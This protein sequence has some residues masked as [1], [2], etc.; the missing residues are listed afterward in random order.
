M[1]VSC[2]YYSQTIVSEDFE[3]SITLFTNSGGVFYTG[4]SATGDRPASSPFAQL[5]SYGIGVTNGT[6]ILT[7]GDINTSTCSGVQLSFKLAAFSIASTG[8]GMDAGDYVSIE[9]SPDG[10]TTY[11]NTLQV[12]GN[13][14]AYWAYATGTGTANTAYDGNVTPVTIAPAGGAA[15]TTDGYSSLIV[16]GLPIVTNLR[17]RITL[18]NNAASERWVMDN[19]ILSGSC[20]SCTAPTTTISPTTQTVCA[21]T[22]TSFTVGSDATSPT[23]TWQASAN[24]TT[25]WANAVNATPTGVTYTGVNTFSLGITGTSAVT[26]YYRVLVAEGGT[27]TATSATST[28]VISSPPSINTHPNSATISTSSSG[29]FTVVAIGGGLSYQWQQNSGGGF[30]NITNGGSNPTYAGATTSVLTISNPPLSMSG[31]S[32]QCVVANNC[33]TVTTNG[34]ATLN[35]ISTPDC[36]YITSVII[37]SCPGT[38]TV[39]AEGNSEAVFITNGASVLNTTTSA[40]IAA[41]IKLSYGTTAAG[42][43]LTSSSV[44]NAATASALACLNSKPGCSGVFVDALGANIPAGAQ[45]MVVRSTF[46]CPTNSTQTSFDELCASTNVPIYVIFSTAP[47]M[48]ANGTFKNGPFSTCPNETRFFRLITPGTC[49]ISTSYDACLLSGFDGDYVTWASSGGT[50]T[51]YGNN[52]CAIPIAI[53]PIELLDFYATKNGNKNDV[54]WKVAQEVNIV[55]YIIEKSN[56]AINFTEMGTIFPTNS[57]GYKTYSLIDENPFNDIT[58]Y[59]L[60]TKELEGTIIQ[61]KIVSIDNKDNKWQYSSY[62]LEN[63]LHIDFKNHLPKQSVISLFDITGKVILTQK[64]EASQN[65]INTESIAKGLYFVQ[66]ATPYKTENFKVVLH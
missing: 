7:T 6:A 35:V 27:C 63:N 37:D 48:L 45:I 41:N 16:T 31:Y 10:G 29:S 44:T 56:D 33:G 58:Y 38:P 61:H 66:I 2:Q 51:N 3:N 64:V 24:G 1:F 23:Y 60:S 5:N 54:I 13:S 30:S 32:Y 12:N 47:A 18:L 43:P 57:I 50:P 59:R 25:G 55:N 46:C 4:N 26:Y 11:Y 53:L 19:F 49:T 62:Q 21:N 9:I 14:N 22:T 36:P 17:V 20:T 15:R 34:T 40:N 8:N 65:T 52:G 28:F 42:N 39:C